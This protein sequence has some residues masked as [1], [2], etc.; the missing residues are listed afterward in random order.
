MPAT[1]HTDPLRV[2]FVFPNGTRRTADFTDTANAQLTADLVRGLPELVHPHG[3]VGHWNTAADYVTT[4]RHFVAALAAEGYGGGASGITRAALVR[5][6]LA[7]THD[8]VSMSRRILAAAHRVTGCLSPEAH[9][10]VQG[11]PMKRRTRTQPTRPYSDAEWDRLQAAMRSEVRTAWTSHQEALVLA[12]AGGHP[13]DHGLNR[14]SI[15]WLLLR[16]GPLG[17][18]DFAPLSGIP[19][20]KLWGNQDLAELREALYP[21]QA[22]MMAH[23]LLFG[24]YTGIVPDGLDDLDL[25]GITWAGDTTVLLDY[26]KG[27]RGAE[28]VTLTKQ[29]VRLLERW[30]ELSRLLRAHARPELA[31]SL[32][33]RT[34]RRSP[35]DDAA[36]TYLVA[37]LDGTAKYRGS[38][39]QV[40][41]ARTGLV[42]DAGEPMTPHSVRIRA[43]FVNRRSRHGWTGAATIDPNHTPAV[44]GDRYLSAQT[45]AQMDAVERI[46]EEGQ[47]DV[48]RRALPPTVLT[49][50]DAARAA[51]A[52]PET[53]AQLGV[54]TGALAELLAGPR[55]VFTASCKDQLAGVH[56]PAGKPC[57]ARPWVCLLCPL[58]VF[59][60]RHA[61]NLLRLRAFFARQ[62]QQMTTAQF[63][64]VFGPYADRLDREILPRFP[65]AVLEQAAGQVADVD[66]EIP[67]RPEEATA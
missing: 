33:L 19:L 64:A 15:A 3:S 42:D 65:A 27:R 10:L 31:D 28:A 8:K 16:H 46:I 61:A 5:Y 67:L 49:P 32:W 18:Q 21:S 51:L 36:T 22:P 50:D 44:E 55:D 24:T 13:R 20:G 57:P 62:F 41:V 14:A 1:V 66:A 53:A 7:V 37:G 23:R 4:L 17:A 11:R 47:G 58:A 59:L 56:G 6:W 35:H 34:R 2:D 54:D 38:A 40:L 9:T 29:A 26:V 25:S 52:L 63:V 48:L 12:E 39:H 30:L 60:P 43:T 45:P